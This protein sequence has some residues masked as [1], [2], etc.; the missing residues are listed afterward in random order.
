MAGAGGGVS[1]AAAY[2]PM[3]LIFVAASA[4]VLLAALVLG[5][6]L[7]AVWSDR[8]ARRKAAAAVLDRVLT[9]MGASAPTPGDTT[10]PGREAR[11]SS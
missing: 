10:A 8:P 1:V 3:I 11:P 6:L 7:P 4:A 9:T 2:Q 5:V